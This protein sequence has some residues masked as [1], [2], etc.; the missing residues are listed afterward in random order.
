[1]ALGQRSRL[2]SGA[3]SSVKLYLK[4]C[5]LALG[6]CLLASGCNSNSHDGPAAG[7]AFQKPAAA[8]FR[9]RSVAVGEEWGLLIAFLHNDTQ[10]D[11]L[12][13][14]VRVE[15]AGIGSTI[16]VL[17]VQVAPLS[18]IVAPRFVTSG[19]IYKT[20]PPVQRIPD[21]RPLRCAV[22]SLRP[23]SG[24]RMHPGNEARLLVLMRA[25]ENGDFRVTSHDV[26]YEQGAKEYVQRLPVGLIGRVARH[27]APM[28]LDRSQRAC[29]D[30]AK[31]VLP[32]T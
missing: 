9:I 1:M 3:N 21:T 7:T 14:S 4:L 5:S 32:H 28:R 16:R 12:L 19:G 18:P 30:K 13:R 6:L 27:G 22:Q 31:R 2:D 11:V 17:R 23:V 24:F 25:D 8:S 26:T 10:D 29:V 15:G 20:Y